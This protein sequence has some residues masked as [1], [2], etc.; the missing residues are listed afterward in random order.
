MDNASIHYV[1]DLIETQDKLVLNY[2]TSL[3]TYFPDLYPVEG[4]SSQ[5]KSIMKLNDKLIQAT[6]HLEQC[7]QLLA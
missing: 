3:H 5:A 7:L 4:V 6:T 1:D 2:A